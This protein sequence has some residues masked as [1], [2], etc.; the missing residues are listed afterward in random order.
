MRTI[1]W[2]YDA[3]KQAK[4]AHFYKTILKMT[5]A[6]AQEC[7]RVGDAL[8]FKRAVTVSKYR[9]EACGKNPQSCQSTKH[10]LKSRRH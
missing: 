6:Q 5:D 9:K 3:K 8:L 1:M 7:I 4:A 2:K 10:M